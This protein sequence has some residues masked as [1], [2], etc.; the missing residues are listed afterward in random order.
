MSKNL[1]EFLLGKISQPIPASVE[2]VRGSIP[3]VF[4]GNVEKAEIATLSLN[5]SN[6]EFEPKHGKVRC[7]DRTQLDV[8]DSQKLTNEQAEA[9]YQSL[10]LYFCDPPYNPYRT[11]F[12]PLNK[13]FERKGLEYYNDKIIHLDISPWATSKKWNDLSQNERDQIVDT[14]IIQNVIE[15]RGIK[16]LFINGKTAFTVFKKTLKVDDE[17]VSSESFEYKTKNGISRKFIISEAEIFGCRV[18]A[19]NLYIQRSCPQDLVN[20]L[21][22]YL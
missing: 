6:V 1:K 10:L 17:N 8:L 2:I 14:T 16:K 3:I 20:K 15:K 19:W 13:L 22:F 12:N 5:P 4:F 9:V 11:W 18:I 7:L 21:N